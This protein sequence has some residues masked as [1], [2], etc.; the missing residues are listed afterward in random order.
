M[1]KAVSETPF[2]ATLSPNYATVSAGALS[3]NGTGSMNL[4]DG[5]K[6]LSGGV[7]QTNP[8]AISWA[9]GFSA[10]V[11]WIWGARDAQ[12]TNQF[13]NGDGNQFFASIP[14]PFRVNVVGAITHAYGGGT[15]LEFGIGTP[16]GK[17]F[18]VMPW[19]HSVP[20]GSASK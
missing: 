6:Y 12:A 2:V 17:T 20:V 9:P 14:T 5:T 13:L 11:G 8:S 4:Y 7:T 16:G 18:G 10:T 15:A 19:G 3:A 1:A